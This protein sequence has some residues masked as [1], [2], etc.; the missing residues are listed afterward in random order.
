M[1]WPFRSYFTDPISLHRPSVNLL[2]PESALSS[3]PHADIVVDEF[4]LVQNNAPRRAAGQTTATNPFGF[5]ICA[6]DSC[7]KLLYAHSLSAYS[8]P[9]QQTKVDLRAQ[10]ILSADCPFQGGYRLRCLNL[11]SRAIRARGVR[12]T[13]LHLDH[14]WQWS[15]P[16]GLEKRSSAF[17]EQ[18]TLHQPQLQAPTLCKFVS[19]FEW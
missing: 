3:H 11:R 4:E 8:F 15:P 9:L 19:E 10:Q 18:M 14:V 2:Q 6:N 1:S 16:P 12:P 13:F 17:L 7:F 5:M